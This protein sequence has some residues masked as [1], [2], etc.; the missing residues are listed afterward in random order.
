[1]TL[2]RFGL[3]VF[4]GVALAGTSPFAQKAKPAPQPSNYPCVATFRDAGT[5][6]LTSDGRGAYTHGLGSVTCVVV[7]PATSGFSGDLSLYISGGGKPANKRALGFDETNHGVAPGYNAC[8]DSGGQ[9]RIKNILGITTIGSGAVLAY[10]GAFHFRAGAPRFGDVYENG[11]PEL[12]PA[13]VTRT[14][15]CSWTITHDSEI[16]VWEGSGWTSLRGVVMFPFELDVEVTS[17]L[18]GC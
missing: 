18:A 13:T 5:D 10:G 3:S 12:M 16:S 17:G 11:E 4:L 6:A 1:M 15:A 9:L 7:N 8:L 14:S 2:S